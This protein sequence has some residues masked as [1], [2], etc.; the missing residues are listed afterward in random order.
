MTTAARTTKENQS[1]STR[2]EI[3]QPGDQY[4]RQAD[5][6]ADKVVSGSSAGAS[7]SGDGGIIQRMQEDGIKMQMKSEDDE[8]MQVQAREGYIQMQ[9]LEEENMGMA[10]R[11]PSGIRGGGRKTKCDD[12]EKE[13]KLQK[14]PAIQRSAN[15]KSQAS[16][17]IAKKISASRG[18][19]QSLPK[20]VNSEMSNK[21][22][23]DFSNVNI[24]T[25]NTAVQMSRD[26]GANAFTVGNDIYFNQGKYN[27]SSSQGKRLLAHELTH[28][29]QQGASAQMIQA[30]FAIQP[31]NPG[32]TATTL[33]PAQIQEA[34]RYNQRKLG[35][36]SADIVRLVRDV[37]GISPDPAVIDQDLVE[38]IVSWQAVNNLT[39]DGKL[40]PGTAAPL[41]AELRAEGHGRESRQ[42]ARLIRRGKVKKQPKYSPSGTLRPTAS[43][44]TKSVTF[45][46]SAEFEHNPRNGI[47]ASCCEVRQ[48]I[49]W[50][51][52]MRRSFAATGNP[53]P[54][55]GF[56]ARHPANRWIEDRDSSN[57]R[58]GRRSGRH[59][60]P[61]AGDQ[62]LNARGARDQ[63]NGTR[64]EGRDTPTM[65]STDTGQMRF[66]LFVVDV[67]NGG[68]RISNID[69]IT[70]N[71]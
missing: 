68:R 67:C 30:D 53:V 18:S 57:D 33:T 36:G 52:S 20:N 6:V 44:G 48:Q 39:Q 64:Y 50:D 3:G 37:L 70:I 19:G 24:H 17:A 58:Y 31:P 69:T 12:C 4:E 40:G 9:P 63:A 14:Q 25:D 51:A 66:R 28:T 34:I 21:M 1:R 47:F 42:L 43:G 10:T 35:R 23:A 2:L 41:F 65:L 7:S 60:A 29:V 22:G 49:Q 27:P 38:A 71:W 61:G 56:P 62:Y 5:A 11:N 55:G 45:T 54:H 26:L 13:E 59:S 16:P 32:A 15:G 46:F 8:L